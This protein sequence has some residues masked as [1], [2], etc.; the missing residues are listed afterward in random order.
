VQAD[1]KVVSLSVSPVI[2]HRSFFNTVTHLYFPEKLKLAK[3]IVLN[4][5]FSAC[6][7]SIHC[8]VHS[9]TVSLLQQI[10]AGSTY[11]RLHL[12]I[13]NL[14]YEFVWRLGCLVYHLVAQFYGPCRVFNPDSW[15]DSLS[16]LPRDHWGTLCSCLYLE[17]LLFRDLHFTEI[18]IKVV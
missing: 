16:I 6:R 9:V 12:E 10:W 1:G 4:V 17:R 18:N 14:L 15:D 7:K 5:K 13:C 3:S 2:Y 11:S 8:N